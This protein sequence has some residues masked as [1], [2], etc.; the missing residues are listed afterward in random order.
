MPDN[1]EPRATKGLRTANAVKDKDKP[2]TTIGDRATTFDDCEGAK[3]LRIK[4]VAPI[5]IPYNR[6]EAATAIAINALVKEF[7]SCI[8]AS[9]INKVAPRGN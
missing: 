4:S 8:A 6:N 2:L 7:S 9:N 3:A 1:K 5:A